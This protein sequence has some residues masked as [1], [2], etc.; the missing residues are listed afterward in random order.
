MINSDSI[1]AKED[2]E[3]C[4]AGIKKI[5]KYTSLS[6]YVITGL[7]DLRCRIGSGMERVIAIE[8]VLGRDIIADMYMSVS[9]GR[10]SERM[11]KNMIGLHNI[12]NGLYDIMNIYR[13]KESELAQNMELIYA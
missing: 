1:W 11:E 6:R 5:W 8:E 7:E 2:K 4:Y 9:I 10:V 3:Q 13:R 12:I